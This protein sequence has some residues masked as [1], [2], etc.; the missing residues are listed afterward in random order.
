MAVA[1]VH[2]KCVEKGTVNGKV[3]YAVEFDGD[4]VIY[5]EVPEPRFCRVCGC[6]QFN[7][8]QCVEKTGRPCY[9]VEE[10]LCS[11]CQTIQK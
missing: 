1:F 8:S 9:W 7:C 5:H 11:A 6:T 4:K 10:D 3:K 2:D